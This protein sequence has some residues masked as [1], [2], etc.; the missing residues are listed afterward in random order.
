MYSGLPLLRRGPVPTVSRPQVVTARRTV[1]RSA[2]AEWP[3]QYFCQRVLG[4]LGKEGGCCDVEEARVRNHDCSKQSHQAGLRL[5]N[6]SWR[7]VLA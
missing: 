2:R 4:T 6:A 7:P 5:L 1:T 3:D